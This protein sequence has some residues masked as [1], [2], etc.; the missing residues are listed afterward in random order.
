MALLTINYKSKTIGM[1]HQFIAILPEDVSYFNTEI[2]P[3]QLKTMLLL[4][5]L[6]SDETS[7]MRY[8]SIERYANDHQI[9]VIM[10]NADHSGYSNMEFGHKYFDYVLEVLD[11]AHQILPL[12]QKRED[13]F[14][15]GHSMGG[16][17]TIKYALTQGH[18]FAKAS[19]LS[20]VFN[21]Q[22]F[23]DID[24]NDFSGQA[25][26]G[27]D[28][29][30][31]DTELDPYYLVDKAIDES[32][33]IPEL[34]I[35]C[36]TEDQLYEDNKQFIAYLDAQ[37]VSYQFEDGPGEHDYAYWDKAVKRAIEWFVG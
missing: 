11:Y 3:K 9:A 2:E 17:G 35:M 6:S 32:K 16:Y 22:T 27:V 34:L 36:G 25:I 29:M 13:N 7:Y 37:N 1:N 23:I 18:R 10:P 26:A 8:T 28:K 33:V 4:H 30:T 12:S 14:I 21:A 31:Q 24:W 5:G 20:S 19:P 15:A